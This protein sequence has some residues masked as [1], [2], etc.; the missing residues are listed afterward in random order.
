MP[1]KKN[2]IRL[3]FLDFKFLA[4][5][6]VF[7]AMTNFVTCRFKTRQ[8]VEEIRKAV[9]YLLTLYPRL[10][11]IVEPTFFSH[12]LRILDDN[13]RWLEVLFNDSFR[14]RYGLTCDSEEFLEYRRALLNE[15]FSLEQG[16]PIK[17]RYLPDDPNPV[18]YLSIHHIVCDGMSLIHILNSLLSYLN[19]ENPPMVPLD[20]PSLLPAIAWKPYKTLL[21]QVVRSFRLCREDERKRSGVTINPSIHPEVFFGPVD[22][23]Q[24]ILSIGYDDIKTTSKKLRCNYTVLVLAALSIAIIRK[25][26]RKQGR[27]VRINHGVNMRPYYDGKPPVFG[28]YA[29]VV[30]LVVDCKYEREPVQLINEIKDQLKHV[31]HRLKNKELLFPF[32]GEKLLSMLGK[33]YYTMFIRWAK[34]KRLGLLNMSFAFTSGGIGDNLNSHGTK[35]QVCE[36][37]SI[38]PQHGLFIT[39]SIIDKRVNINISFP[40]A[41]FTRSEIVGFTRSFE[42]ELGEIIKCEKNTNKS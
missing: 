38:V 37:L 11:S 19:G 39:M 25:P 3:S 41:E 23:H 29:E 14:V 20:D 7:T 8:D 10:R 6:D 40:E 21:K 31:T 17:V 42:Y 27:V 1:E 15:S 22:M 24:Q 32:L 13:D 30:P 18:L 5:E 33:K 36:A 16:L 28:N 35:A 34:P 2:C 12:R 4:L 9:R 26:G